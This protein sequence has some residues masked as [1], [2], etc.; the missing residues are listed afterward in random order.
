MSRLTVI[1]LFACI[2]ISVPVTAYR[3]RTIIITR[4]SFPAL[5][6]LF[7]GGYVNNTVTAGSRKRQGTVSIAGISLPAL[8]AFF[9]GNY[10]ENAVAAVRIRRYDN[11]I[12]AARSSRLTVI[13][14]FA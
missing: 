14:L 10:I 2:F 1:A 4:C 5:I 3:S 8:I 13:A 9:T 7:T 11:T 6:A 12:Y